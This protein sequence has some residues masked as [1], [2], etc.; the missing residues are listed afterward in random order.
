M[1]KGLQDSLVWR[2]ILNRALFLMDW[3]V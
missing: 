3:I 1:F 2:T